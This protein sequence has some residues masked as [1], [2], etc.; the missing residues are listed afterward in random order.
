MKTRICLIKTNYETETPT[1][2]YRTFPNEIRA[3]EYFNE[4]RDEFVLCDVVIAEQKKGLFSRTW[5]TVR[6]IKSNWGM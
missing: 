1:V 5:K 3:L 6:V 2:T 4:Y